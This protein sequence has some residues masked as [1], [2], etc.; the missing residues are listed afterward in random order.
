MM[1]E[2]FHNMSRIL[3]T[4]QNQNKDFGQRREYN[5]YEMNIK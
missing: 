4:S 2:L 5:I 1:A 3:I